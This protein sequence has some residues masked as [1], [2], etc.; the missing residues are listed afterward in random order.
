MKSN[1]G[2]ISRH[3]WNYIYYS[4]G[5]FVLF[6]LLDFETLSVLFLI[7]ALFFAYLFRN[8]EIEVSNIDANTIF[9]VCDG[10]VTKIE[11]LKE[12]DY[13]YKIEIDTNY[14]DC[15]VLRAPIPAKVTKL[16]LKRGTRLSK[17]A[18]LFHDL[19]EH[20]ELL[21][22]G[23]NNKNILVHHR[24]KQSLA[25]LFID[26]QD[27]SDIMQTFRYGV[28]IDSITSIYLPKNAVLDIRV[29]EKTEAGQTQ[30]AHLS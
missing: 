19:N 24:L 9:S 27:E 8:P 29:G 3:G 1:T 22:I 6:L 15:A 26:V 4:L 2:I 21:F 11:E 10:K 18:K 25:P 5:V 23:E 14:F 12:E 13:G 16:S 17:G 28:A 7:V 20:A 30:L